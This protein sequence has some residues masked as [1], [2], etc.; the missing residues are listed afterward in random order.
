MIRLLAVVAAATALGGPVEFGI[1]ELQRAIAARGL[2]PGVI[3]FNTEI[4]ADPPETYR[5][6]PGRI[7]GG[8]VRG[9]MY[10]L[11]EAAEQ[12]RANGRLVS[13]KG[14]PATPLRGIRW[15]VHNRDLEER[16]YYS[17]DYW[18]EFF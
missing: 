10:G 11:L 2:K 16:W 8:D 7:S 18:R 9:L 6:I 15:F 4:S 17:R 5:I 12:I 3:R 14:A 1:A 13:A